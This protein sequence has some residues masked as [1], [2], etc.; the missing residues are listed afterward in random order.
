[1]YHTRIYEYKYNNKIG[2]MAGRYPYSGYVEER[3]ADVI[4]YDDNDERRIKED[5]KKG[6]NDKSETVSARRAE[7]R[8]R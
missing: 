8:D 4:T 6:I 2:E 7:S 5:R 1:L 3:T